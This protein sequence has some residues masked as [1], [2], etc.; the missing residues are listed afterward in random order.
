MRIM[1]LSPGAHRAL[2]VRAT[3]PSHCDQVKQGFLCL[4]FLQVQLR[5]RVSVTD[6]RVRPQ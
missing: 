2:Q 5:E 3:E 4:Y 1:V 6:F